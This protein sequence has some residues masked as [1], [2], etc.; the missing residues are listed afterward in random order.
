VHVRN[1]GLGPATLAP[2]VILSTARGVFALE[3]SHFSVEE[4]YDA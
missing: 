2:E 1:F 3:G 4:A